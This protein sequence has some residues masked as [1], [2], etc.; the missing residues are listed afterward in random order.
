MESEQDRLR[1]DL[2]VKNYVFPL[3]AHQTHPLIYVQEQLAEVR[4]ELTDI[5]CALAP[6]EFFGRQLP[7]C[8]ASSH[9]WFLISC[10]KY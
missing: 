10:C 6:T 8:R 7:V 3:P 1:P 9:L 4:R 5:T 2:L